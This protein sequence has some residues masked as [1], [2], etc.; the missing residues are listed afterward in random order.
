[1][2]AAQKVLECFRKD[3]VTTSG[4]E[5]EQRK[6]PSDR[7][8]ERRGKGVWKDEDELVEDYFDLDDPSAHG[9]DDDGELNEGWRNDPDDDHADDYTFKLNMY[10]R[11][12]SPEESVAEN[13][14]RIEVDLERTKVER[15]AVG[16]KNDELSFEDRIAV[17]QFETTDDCDCG[18]DLSCNF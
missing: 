13:T 7:N 17:E 2:A 18:V 10:K 12:V 8:M 6:H 5:C 4:G 1:M 3:L 16:E 9:E 14:T 15:F 11:K